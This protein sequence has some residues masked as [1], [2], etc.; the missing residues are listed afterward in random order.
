MAIRD[1]KRPF[2]VRDV[3]D[4]PR[5]R[6]DDAEP[7]GRGPRERGGLEPGRHRLD[8]AHLGLR[9]DERRHLAGVAAQHGDVDLVE[10]PAR[11]LG[12]VLSGA[13]TD[14]IEDD[15]DPTRAR[16]PAR[17]QHRVDPVLRERA[18]VEHQGRG[19]P[20]HLLDLL[21]RVCHHRQRAES[22]RCV[23]RLVHD[24]VIRDLVDERLP[25]AQHAQ[26]RSG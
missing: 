5:D 6:G 4:R 26:R 9:T 21:P 18:D 8:P 25:L 13:D 11:G 1:R 7:A 22:Q 3:V 24:D 12:A 23:R 2:A 16:G 14:G 15:R 20:D 10:D 17:K 19:E